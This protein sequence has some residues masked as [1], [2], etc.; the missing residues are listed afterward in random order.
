MNEIFK[1]EEEET[2]KD[3]SLGLLEQSLMIRDAKGQPPKNRPIQTWELIQEIETLCT[4]A[5]LNVSVEHIYVT[6]AG[7]NPIINRGEKELYKNGDNIPIEKWLFSR[8]AMQ[9][10]IHH[11]EDLDS[12]TAIVFSYHDKGLQIAMGQHVH[13]CS[14]MCI[15]GDNTMYTFGPDRMPFDK[16]MD[17]LKGWIGDFEK[18]RAEDLQM[19]EQ[20]RN[21]VLDDSNLEDFFDAM[22]GRLYRNA[23]AQAY[24]KGTEG[25][26]NVSQCSSFVQHFENEWKNKCEE[27][28]QAVENGEDSP[29]DPVRFCM[30]LWEIYNWGTQ[31]IKPEGNDI[32][33]IYDTI[34][35]WG[36][37]I[38][39]FSGFNMEKIDLAEFNKK[40]QWEQE[41]I[42]DPL[43][44]ILSKEEIKQW[45]ED[46][47][48]SYKTGDPVNS[49]WHPVYR[50]ECRI[51]N[52]E[53]EAKKTEPVDATPETPKPKQAKSIKP[54]KVDKKDEKEE[55]F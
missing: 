22:V 48:K 12:K 51:I 27:F 44:R 40:P 4:E 2:V 6:R 43:F 26:F 3:I 28:R 20:M 54:K 31:V 53:A 14:N 19:I 35:K 24:H 25:V 1:F 45:R 15:F 46:C 13:V 10:F 42:R 38:A 33:M 7:S 41:M 36:T 29:K 39:K 30:T 11:K 8:V 9:M 23:I 55:D 18:K 34:A 50:D 37:F 17:V 52:E 5:K 21:F 16:I 32:S 49:V 47:R